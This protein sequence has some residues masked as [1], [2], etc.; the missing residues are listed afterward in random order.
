[1]DFTS[2]REWL[3][4]M[5]REFNATEYAREMF[6]KGHT[7]DFV[8][9]A[10]EGMG[11]SNKSARESARLARRLPQAHPRAAQGTGSGVTHCFKLPREL[12]EGLRKEAE[13]RRISAHALAG[14]LVAAIVDDGLYGAILDE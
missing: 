12:S 4:D 2:A 6:A 10:I 5:S 7:F 13:R 3:G 14:E 8:V 1:M 11:R 9:A